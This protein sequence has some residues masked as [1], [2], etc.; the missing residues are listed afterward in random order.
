MGTVTSPAGTVHG[1]ALTG[2]TDGGCFAFSGVTNP[3]PPST[4]AQWQY[5]GPLMSNV[6][7]VCSRLS[8][9]GNYSPSEITLRLV[10]TGYADYPGNA[11]VYPPAGDLPLTLQVGQAVT[12]S[13]GVHRLCAPYVMQAQKNGHPGSDSSATGGTVTYTQ[14]DSTGL[15]GSWDLLFNG[16]HTTGAF[17]CA[18]C[19]TPPG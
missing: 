3:I 5:V 16:D 12:T 2:L 7:G 10:L 11:P 18:W 8:G 13:D 19:G 4:M 17:D 6:T 1:L 9:G 14:M 15:A